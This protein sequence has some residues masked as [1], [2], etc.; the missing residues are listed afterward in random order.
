MNNKEKIT[1]ILIEKGKEL[2][3]TPPKFME[4]TKEKE[5][6]TLLKLSKKS[7]CFNGRMNCV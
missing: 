3:K 5:A 6:D 2:M 7:V 1:Q 4:F